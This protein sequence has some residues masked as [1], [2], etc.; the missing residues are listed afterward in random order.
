[1]NAS[2]NLI[3]QFIDEQFAA[4]TPSGSLDAV[5]LFMDM[6][7]F[8]AMTQAF[9][10]RGRD[11]AETL[12]TILNHVFA[13]VVQAVYEQGGFITG[14]AGD[15]FTALFPI[16]EPLRACAAALN[17][18]TLIQQ[19]QHQATPFGEFTIAVRMGLAAGPVAW[20]IVGTERQRTYF[21][22]G[23][24]IDACTTAEDMAQPGDI[25]LD[26]P[27]QA[28]L[29]P[30]QALIAPLPDAPRFAR[31]QGLAAYPEPLPVRP[32]VLHHQAHFFPNLPL[33]SLSQGEYREAAIIF[34]AFNTDL[35]LAELDQLMRRIIELAWQFGGHF[36]ELDFGDKGSMALLYFGAPVTHERDKERALNFL[37]ALQENLGRQPIPSLQ[38]RASVA[39]G[40]VYAGMIG[41]PRRG[42]YTCLGSTVNLAARQVDAAAWGHIVVSETVAQQTDFRFA[43]LGTY[44]YKGFTEPATTYRLLGAR[45]LA[46]KFFAAPMVGRDEELARLHTFAAPLAE[47]KLAGVALVYGEPGIGKS[48]LTYALRQALGEQVSWF[49]GQADP[50]LPQA[51]GPFVYWLRRTFGQLADARAETNRATFERKLQRLLDRLPEDEDAAAL[52]SELIRTQSCLGALLGHHWP[53][54]LYESLDA[55]GRYHNTFQAIKTL[56]L[57][58]SRLRPVVLEL[59]DAHRMDDASRELFTFLTRQVHT[60]P[61]LLLLTSRYRDDGSRPHYPI[62]AA[63]PVLELDLAVLSAAAVCHL[64]AS[65]LHHPITPTLEAILLEKSQANPFFAEQLL[66][67][68][69]ENDLLRLEP[70]GWH[71]ATTTFTL[72]SSINAILIARIDRLTAQVKEVVKVAAVLGREFEVRILSQ[73]LRADVLPDVKAAEQEQIWAALNELRYIFRHTLLRDAAYEMQLRT[74]LRELHRLA[75]AAYEQLYAADLTPYYPD[76]AYHY[77]QAQLPEPERHYARKAA[78]HAAAQYANQAALDYFSR[79]LE[80]TP[81]D[82]VVAQYELLLQREQLYDRVGNREA[83]WQDI[84]RLLELTQQGEGALRRQAEA[85]L[86]EVEYTRVT[87]N[88]AVAAAQIA[89]LVELLTPAEMPDL[90]GKAYADW[91]EILLRQG[92]HAAAQEKLQQALALARQAQQPQLE[93]FCLNG[94]GNVFTVSLEHR[95]ARDC[96]EEALRLRRQLGDRQEISVTLLNLGSVLSEMGEPDEALAC[97]EECLRLKKLT[98][99]LLGQAAVYNNLGNLYVRHG[100]LGQGQQYFEQALHLAR[101]VNHRRDEAIISYNLGYVAWLMGDAAAVLPWMDTALAIVDEI[102]LRIIRGFAWTLR[103]RALILLSRYDEAQHWLEQAISER[104]AM[105]L[106]GLVIETQAE[107]AGLYRLQGRTD[108]AVHLAETVLSFIEAGDWEG[109]EDPFGMYWHCWQVF[110]EGD[111]ARARAILHRAYHRLQATADRIQNHDLRQNFL[112]GVPSHRRLVTA[113]QTEF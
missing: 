25:I 59:E 66:Y 58:E 44:A 57:A 72:P 101:E 96:M 94:L 90:L 106:D 40:L 14:F 98:G 7:G 35:P 95:Q 86:L 10:Q 55:Q 39:F 87:K 89:I 16:D 76:L 11:G 46:D 23:R 113:Y 43:W 63:T 20:G 6:T 110:R 30:Q 47:G 85:R 83:Q 19:E 34:I 18:H 64:A 37:L 80:L 65:L 3:P 1:M 111:E 32:I 91:G 88:Y 49:V 13:P 31:L 61:L 104:Q 50:I 92:Q 103:G 36:N 108:A 28:L 15:A 26:E 52:R 109:L 4:A 102:G 5:T 54:S 70:Q 77:G 51:F 42:K 99:E 62:A 12:S 68:F 100:G 27:V 9:M 24:G 79:V 97:Y 33:A 93:A 81:S 75:A 8:T 2:Y 38:W 105:H 41:A 74:R 84:S 53:D 22:R 112:H 67:Y 21:F 69:R 56:L 73:V 107:L 17:I 48:R 71:V 29:R 60:Y 82:D 78:E 45:S